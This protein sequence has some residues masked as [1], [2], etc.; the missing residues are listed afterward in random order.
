VHQA[1]LLLLERR[2]AF[3]AALTAGNHDQ[4]QALGRR[5]ALLV[6][7]QMLR[8]DSSGEQQQQQQQP[9]Q[10]FVQVCD[11]INRDFHLK[12]KAAP[13]LWEQVAAGDMQPGV[14]A[15]VQVWRARRVDIKKTLEVRQALLPG[16]THQG[17]RL[18]CV[19]CVDTARDAAWDLCVHGTCS[20][21]QI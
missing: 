8:E 15:F 16:G 10:H 3:C 19:M 1:L 17:L 7:C 4:L 13:S 21:M 6:I 20:R 11:V 2:P 12:T 9:S 14:P 18:L 5:A